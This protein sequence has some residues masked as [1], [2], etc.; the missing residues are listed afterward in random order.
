M[1]DPHAAQIPIWAKLLYTLMVSVVVIVYSIKYKP[2]NFLWFSD[3]ALIG[4]AIAMWLENALLA[5]MMAVAVLLPELARSYFLTLRTGAV[6]RHR[7][8]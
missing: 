2:S 3:I 7:S 4:C 1:S 6:G 8:S 5:S